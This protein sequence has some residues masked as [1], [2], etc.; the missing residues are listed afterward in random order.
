MSCSEVST[1]RE[2]TPSPVPSSHEIEVWTPQVDQRLGFLDRRFA[3]EP[4]ELGTKDPVGAV[5]EDHDGDVELFARHRPQRLDRVQSRAVGL[6]CDDRAVRARDRRPN[7]DRKSLPDRAPRQCEPVVPGSPCGIGR[8]RRCRRDRFVGDNRTLR[9]D[10]AD[11]LTDLLRRSGPSGGGGTTIL[12]PGSASASIQ[13]LN[14]LLETAS[15]R[16]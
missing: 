13:R 8:Q 15:T 4:R 6:E 3:V 9:Q 12:Q 7:R 11:R 14:Q 1:R 10:R 2:G 5:I 16:T